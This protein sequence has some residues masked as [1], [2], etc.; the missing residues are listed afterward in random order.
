MIVAVHQAVQEMTVGGTAEIVAAPNKA[1]GEADANV[2]GAKVVRN[3]Q[4]LVRLCLLG[5]GD[6]RTPNEKTEEVC[7]CAYCAVG[8]I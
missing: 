7:V 5:V 4:V 1:F 3:S 6:V 2:N 8:C